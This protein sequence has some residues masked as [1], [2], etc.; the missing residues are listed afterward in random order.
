MANIHSL[1]N[2]SKLAGQIEMIVLIAGL[3]CMKSQARH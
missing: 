3:F 1:M 2:F